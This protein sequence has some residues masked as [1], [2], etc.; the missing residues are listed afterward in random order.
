MDMAHTKSLSTWVNLTV[1]PSLQFARTI[2]PTIRNPHAQEDLNRPVPE[3]PGDDEDGHL[4]FVLA[5]EV[6]L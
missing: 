3:F 2:R 5:G 4:G 1:S 6:Q